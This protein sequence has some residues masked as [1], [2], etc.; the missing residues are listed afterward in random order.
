MERERNLI[1]AGKG[2]KCPGELSQ[3]PVFIVNQNTNNVIA[4]NR[5][6]LKTTREKNAE[7][8]IRQGA[9]WER[10]RLMY[11]EMDRR[12]E[13]ES[14]SKREAALIMEDGFTKSNRVRGV[15]LL[16]FDCSLIILNLFLFVT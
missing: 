13:I 11:D 14:K 10:E 6:K 7:R 3:H 15:D 2:E 4:R 1:M 12:K 8:L 16:R 5:A 9:K